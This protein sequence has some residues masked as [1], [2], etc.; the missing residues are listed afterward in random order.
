MPHFVRWYVA[1]FELHE[2]K[3]EHWFTEKMSNTLAVQYPSA[4][5]QWIV[6]FLRT[7]S[8]THRDQGAKHTP[9]LCHWVTNVNRVTCKGY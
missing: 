2:E 4:L 1:E 3:L 7:E 5:L 6:P 9:A 8:T